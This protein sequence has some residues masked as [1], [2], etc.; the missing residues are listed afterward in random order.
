[1]RTGIFP[2]PRHGHQDATSKSWRKPMRLGLATLRTAL[3]K[4]A[5]A[6]V[7]CVVMTAAC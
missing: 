5:P 6:L 4:A 2:R 7:F 3:G 1:M